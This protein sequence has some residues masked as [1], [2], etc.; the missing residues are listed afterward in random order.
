MGCIPTPHFPHLIR[1]TQDPPD[2]Q[3]LTLA[4]NKFN[5][6]ATGSR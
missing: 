5:V 1:Y 4:T 3:P 2:L 6:S